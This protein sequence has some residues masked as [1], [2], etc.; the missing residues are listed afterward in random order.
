MTPP[1]AGME[2]I[3][4]P[5]EYR[6]P[7]RWATVRAVAGVVLVG[8]GLTTLAFGGSDS[9]TYIWT[10]AFL[11]AGAADLAFARWLQ[12]IARSQANRL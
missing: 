6:H 10:L 7:R 1:R 4:S 5:W 2:R 3:I 11:A 9:A 8:L 12:R